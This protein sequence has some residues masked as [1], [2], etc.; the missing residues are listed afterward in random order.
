MRD[1]LVDITIWGWHATDLEAASEFD[2]GLELLADVAIK[3]SQLLKIGK[4]ENAPYTEGSTCIYHE[5]GDDKPCYK[6]MFK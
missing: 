4:P 2:T 6:T 1:L 5:H 3:Q